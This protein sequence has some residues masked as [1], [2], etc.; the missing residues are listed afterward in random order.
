M[1]QLGKKTAN[2]YTKLSHF[3]FTRLFPAPDLVFFPVLVV[4]LTPF[5][6]VVL[7]VLLFVV[8]RTPALTVVVLPFDVLVLLTC[9]RFFTRVEDRGL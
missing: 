4:F 3:L 7:P 8:L 2:I 9:V 1:I 5:V 6:T